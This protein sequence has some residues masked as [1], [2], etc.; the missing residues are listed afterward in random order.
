ML[1]SADRGQ[2]LDWVLEKLSAAKKGA[3]KRYT[4]VPIKTDEEKRKELK[5]KQPKEIELWKEYKASGWQ[6]DKLDP[7]L[8]SFSG[9]INSRINV[10]RN[11]VEVPTTVIEQEHKR[12]F[13]DALRTYDPKKAALNTHIT[14]R[15]LK[16]GRLIE[17]NKN[18]TYIPENV[19]KNIGV[20]NAFKA[21][22][23]EKFGYEPDDKTLHDLALTSG[24]K[25][26]Q[27]LSIK[28]IKRLNTDQRKGLIQQG[29]EADVLHQDKLD[30]R[31]TEVAQLI[32]YQLTPQERAVHEYTVGLNGK[33]K[34]KAGEIAKKL[35][36][37]N[38]KVSKI[39][40]SI[41]KKMAPYL[42]ES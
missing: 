38:S 33:P 5:D 7:L 21:E 29:F 18:I 34:L 19:S 9:L 35:K 20:F 8:K 22:Q 36:M 10:Y 27:S 25:K 17:A 39:R 40:T 30:P 28:D 6:P 41:W 26:L 32:V 14:K 13:A 12:W 42:E 37:D 16:G 23:R 2:D 31:E 1:A 4:P 11:R 3:S 24:N 15:L